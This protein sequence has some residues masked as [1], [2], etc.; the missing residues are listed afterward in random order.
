M[1]KGSD[2]IFEVYAAPL[3][4]HEIAET[5]KRLGPNLVIETQNKIFEIFPAIKNKLVDHY[6]Q[7]RDESKF[8]YILK[9]RQSWK[10]GKLCREVMEVKK[11]DSHHI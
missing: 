1:K 4:N 3:I 2:K 7:S 9:V 8:K 6:F 11:V 5:A 10:G